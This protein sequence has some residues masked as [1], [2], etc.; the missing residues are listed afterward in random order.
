MGF[1]SLENANDLTNLHSQRANGENVEINEKIPICEEYDDH[2]VHVTEHTRF[3]L[4][5]TVEKIGEQAK[6]RLIEHLN[7]HKLM[8][9]KQIGNKSLTNNDSVNSG[10]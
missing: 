3:L 1:G 10:N 9:V 4:S 8:A 5:N 7:Q 2:E 6:Q